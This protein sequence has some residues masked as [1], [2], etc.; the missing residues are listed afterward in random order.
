MAGTRDHA[1]QLA[2]LGSEKQISHVFSLICNLDIL[3][4]GFE[5]GGGGTCL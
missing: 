4:K 3:K 5:L 2:Q 1:S